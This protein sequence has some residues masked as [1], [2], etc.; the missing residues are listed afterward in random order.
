MTTTGSIWLDAALIL[1]AL[2]G[3]FAVAIILNGVF[4]AIDG[5]RA[6]GMGCDF[7]R[8]NAPLTD[9]E[10]LESVNDDVLPPPQPEAVRKSGRYYMPATRK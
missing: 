7:R 8:D 9:R 10:I 4:T 3:V 5:L 1:I 2:G 6:Q